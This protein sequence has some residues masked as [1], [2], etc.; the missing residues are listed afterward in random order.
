MQRQNAGF[1]T[2]AKFTGKRQETSRCRLKTVPEARFLPQ[3]KRSGQRL[4]PLAYKNLTLQ[5]V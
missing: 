5:G 1:V 2:L 3:A 4:M